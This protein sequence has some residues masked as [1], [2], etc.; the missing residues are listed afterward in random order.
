MGSILDTPTEAQAA[1]DE[2]AGF[3][4]FDYNTAGDN[5][6]PDDIAAYSLLSIAASLQCIASKL[7]EL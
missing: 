5:S 6:D 3:A 1:R 2:L 4:R 7:E